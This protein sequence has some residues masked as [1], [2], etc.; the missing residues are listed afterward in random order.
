MS[1]PHLAGEM[2][3]RATE[4]CSKG[5]RLGFCRE[6]LE[7]FEASRHAVAIDGPEVSVVALAR[8]DELDTVGEAD[9]EARMYLDRIEVTD[10]EHPRRRDGKRRLDGVERLVGVAGLIS[11]VA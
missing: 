6:V 4:T 2:R 1:S 7:A 11:R 3:I 9:D 10:G 5:F 8:F